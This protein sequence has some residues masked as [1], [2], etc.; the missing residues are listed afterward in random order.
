MSS[1]I[2]IRLRC[3]IVLSLLGMMLSPASAFAESDYL[4]MTLEELMDVPVYSAAKKMETVKDT[5][6][7]VYVISAEDIARSTATSV[8]EL[9]RIAPGVQ[10]A[11]ISSNTWSVAIR[12]FN[13]RFSNKL[14]VLVDGRTVYNPVFSGVYWNLQDTVLED[15]ERIEIVRGPGGALWGAN[16][17]NGVINIITKESKDTTGVLVSAGGGTEDHGVLSLRYGKQIEKGAYRIYAKGYQRDQSADPFSGDAYD[18]TEGGQLGFRSDWELSEKDTFQVQGHGYSVN[19]EAEYTDPSSLPSFATSRKTTVDQVGGNILARWLREHD[20]GSTTQLQAYYDRD[21]RDDLVADI[22][23]N[24]FDLEAEHR[25][26]LNE[27]NEISAGIGFRDIEERTSG[28]D[29]FFTA[30][31][32]SKNYRIVNFF[33][34]DHI[35]LSDSLRLI[36]GAKLSHNDFSHDEIQPNARAIWQ[37]NKK[38]SLWAAISRAVRT[39]N[40]AAHHLSGNLFTTPVPDVGPVTTQLSPNPEFGSEKLIAYEIGYRSEVNSRVQFDISAFLYDYDDLSGIRVL[41]TTVDSSSGEPTV[42]TPI[43]FDNSLEGE[44]YGAELLIDLKLSDWWRMQGTYSFLRIELR[45]NNPFGQS[46]GLL[47]EEDQ[48]PQHQAGIRSMID[49]PHDLE[50][51]SFLR[52]VDRLSASDTDSHLQLDLR[53]GW[54]INKN[55]KLDLIG[56]NLLDNQHDEFNDIFP[57]VVDAHQ[58]RS[59]F[60]RVT[61]KH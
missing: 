6:A 45:T 14:L 22:R 48:N 54:N 47:E 30:S 34:Q 56:N 60:A 40:R 44:S 31:P 4:Q 41:D 13:G 32:E 9:L 1:N 5:A 52:Y 17:V 43:V 37:L 35:R 33:L 50:F 49:L 46:G 28:D 25:V 57:T 8:P 18:K 19:E 55:F 51:D 16:A 36:L 23:V 59:V 29:S 61:F 53:F 3:L 26:M 20:G 27:S 7:A 38:S 10:V 15:I 42:I 2:I 11:R 24:T 12:G 58:E 39:P 21:E